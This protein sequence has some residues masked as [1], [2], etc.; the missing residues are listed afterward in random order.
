MVKHRFG[1]R[2]ARPSVL[3]SRPRRAWLHREPERGG[4][5]SLGGFPSRAI[6]GPRGGS[7]AIAGIAHLS[8]VPAVLAAKAAAPTIPIVFVVP[9]DPVQLGLVANLNRPGGNLTG[10]AAVNAPVLMKQ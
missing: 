7:G 10:V 5:V 2:H 6:A 1:G 3:S 4:Q 9:T 8:G